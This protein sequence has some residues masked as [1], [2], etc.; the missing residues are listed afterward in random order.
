MWQN[1]CL[2]RV[3]LHNSCNFFF[4]LKLFQNNELKVCIE[5]IILEQRSMAFIRFSNG[6]RATVLGSQR[7]RVRS[8]VTGETESN[9]AWNRVHSPTGAQRGLTWGPRGSSAAS[10]GP[11]S[12]FNRVSTRWIISR[13]RLRNPARSEGRMNS[14]YTWQRAAEWGG[15]AQLSHSSLSTC[16]DL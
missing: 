15:R 7:W 13:I 3:S 11:V 2:Q 1:S 12:L 9:E 6:P 4:C 16:L 10:T 14:L 8:K 5:H